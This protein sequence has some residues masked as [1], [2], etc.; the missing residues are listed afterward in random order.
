MLFFHS[1]FRQDYRLE[2]KLLSELSLDYSTADE[3]QLERLT[4]GS[5]LSSKHFI[6]RVVVVSHNGV[7]TFFTKPSQQAPASCQADDQAFFDNDSF[8]SGSITWY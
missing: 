7:E 4:A 2:R 1:R 6:H 5:S 3:E 8:W